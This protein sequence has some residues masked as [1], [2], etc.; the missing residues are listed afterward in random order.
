MPRSREPVPPRGPPGR[1]RRTLAACV[2]HEHGTTD[3][4]V[5]ERV[6]QAARTRDAGVAPPVLGFF[7]PRRAD[8]GWDAPFARIAYWNRFGMPPGALTRIG[9]YRDAVTL[10]W[11]DPQKQQAEIMRI[12]KDHGMSP[13]S[14]LSGCLP[15]LIPMPVLMALFFVF[16]NTIEFRG[17]PFLW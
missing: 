16:Q 2:E 8:G 5:I 4:L 6:P 7:R 12:Y 15:A 13:L 10:W 11:I 3:L 17:V 1:G 9:D 14:P